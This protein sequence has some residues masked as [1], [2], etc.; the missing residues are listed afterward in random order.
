MHPNSHLS[1]RHFLRSAATASVGLAGLTALHA[2]EPQPAN[3]EYGGFTVGVQSYTFRNFN[4][5]QAL[6]RIRDLGLHSVEL[7]RGHVPTTSTP[8]QIRAVRTLCQRYDI[9]PIAFGVERFTSNHEQNRQLFEFGRALGIRTFSA[10]PDPDSFNSLDR[11]VEEFNINIAIH[12]HG[13]QGQRLHRWYSAEEIMN[14]VR[15]HNRRIG[16]CLDTGHLI[17]SAQ[18]PFNRDL[19]PAQ[20]VRVMGA[21]NFGLHLKDHDNQQRRDVVFGQGSLNVLAVL[22]ALRGVNF[23]GY[24]SIEYEANPDNPSPDVQACLQVLRG[25]VRQLG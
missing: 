10:D 4:L 22:R 12:P 8:E 9:T 16:S 24:L 14:A 23:T 6:Q 5:E 11:L 25:A 3:N 18:P 20:Q 2:D 15:N 19:D 13:P 17:R 7:Y 1:R 21:R